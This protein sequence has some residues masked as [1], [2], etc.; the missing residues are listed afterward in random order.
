MDLK[1]EITKLLIADYSSVLKTPFI[2]KEWLSNFKYQANFFRKVPG[3]MW[4][5]ADLKVRNLY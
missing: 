2:C 1:D 4:E 5:T 3:E